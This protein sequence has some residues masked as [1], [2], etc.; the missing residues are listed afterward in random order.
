MFLHDPYFL[1]RGGLYLA[2]C[3]FLYRIYSRP[4]GAQE[5]FRASWSYRIP[6]WLS[7]VGSGFFL[8][9]IANGDATRTLHE[10]L[11]WTLFVMAAGGLAWFPG[12][13]LAD[14]AGVEQRRLLHRRK[15][16]AW[17]EVIAVSQEW[18]EDSLDPWS[19]GQRT[20]LLANDGTEIRFSEWNVKQDRF[21]WWVRGHVPASS[22]TPVQPMFITGNWP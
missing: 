22:L 9:Q 12:V 20:T 7:V 10:R 1:I 13:I 14:E 19:G 11:A 15:R 4:R 17:S 2:A 6:V 5:G 18:E 21:E 16:I 3:E 8:W